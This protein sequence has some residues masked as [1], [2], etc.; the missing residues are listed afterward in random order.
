MEAAEIAAAPKNTTW[1]VLAATTLERYPKLTP[2]LTEEDIAH[3]KFVEEMMVAKSALYVSTH[4]RFSTDACLSCRN[5]SLYGTRPTTLLSPATTKLSRRRCTKTYQRPPQVSDR[6]RPGREACRRGKAD[7]RGRRGQT[8]CSRARFRRF[9]R[10]VAR[11]SGRPR[12]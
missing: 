8:G 3:G 10:R 4:H 2:A 6:N 9:R 1:Q 7:R 11:D 5:L 12:G